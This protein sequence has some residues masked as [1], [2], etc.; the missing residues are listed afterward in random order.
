LLIIGDA[1]HVM[2]PVGGVGIN[3]AIADAVEAANVLTLPLRGG[4]IEHHHLA[5]VQRRRERFTQIIQRF[6]RVMQQRGLGETLEDARPFSMPL[7]L[8]VA[9]RIPGL[10]DLPPRVMAFGVRRPRLERPE[11]LPVG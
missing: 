3:C 2:L 11:E 7:P 6:Q 10:R 5:E 1:A 9:L 8:R 4:R